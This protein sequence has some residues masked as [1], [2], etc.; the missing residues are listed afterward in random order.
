MTT[1]LL[2]VVILWSD[3]ASMKTTVGP[4]TSRQACEAVI[5]RVNHAVAKELVGPPP[6]TI[7]IRCEEETRS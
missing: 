2:L 4:F 1:F 6:T 5:G 7:E 3:G